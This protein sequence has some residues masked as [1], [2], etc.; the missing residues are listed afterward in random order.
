MTLNN[1]IR[2]SKLV[3]EEFDPCDRDENYTPTASTH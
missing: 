2:D 3:D 1:F